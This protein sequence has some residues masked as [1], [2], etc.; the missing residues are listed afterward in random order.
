GRLPGTLLGSEPAD[1]DQARRR[2]RMR[3]GRGRDH[4]HDKDAA[5]TRNAKKAA[6]DTTSPSRDN[7]NASLLSVANNIR[8]ERNDPVREERATLV[9]GKRGLDQLEFEESV[10]A[11]GTDPT[12][13]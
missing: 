13:E 4:E 1:I 3:K 7:L 2:C 9:L 5:R 11:Q 10:A 8:P 6:H 12:P